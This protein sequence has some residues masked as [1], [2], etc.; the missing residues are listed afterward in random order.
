MNVLD[1]KTFTWSKPHSVPPRYNHSATLVDRKL[2]IYAGKDESGKTVSDLFVVDLDSLKVL[3]QMGLSGE[4]AL[5]KSQHF[6]E[7]IGNQQMMVFG[8]HGE[9]EYGMWLLDLGTLHWKTLPRDRCF[10]DGVWNY[11]TACN[12]DELSGG[13]IN[14]QWEATIKGKDTSI[15]LDGRQKL[16]LFLGN[17]D[18]ERPQPYDHFKDM[19]LVNPEIMFLWQ[20]PEAKL[21]DDFLSL[22]QEGQDWADY[23]IVSSTEE[24]SEPVKC[25]RAVL[26]SRWQHFRHLSRSGMR[27][28]SKAQLRLPESRLVIETFV[29]FLYTDQL[30]DLIDAFV[31]TSLLVMGNLYLLP[32][33]SKLCCRKL[34]TGDFLTVETCAS[35]FQAAV[36]A[37]EEGL[38]ALILE[39]M[40]RH[41]GAILR[42]RSLMNMS[43]QAWEEFLD[44]VPEDGV[45]VSPSKMTNTAA[46]KL[47]S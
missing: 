12:A 7:Y 36:E 41:H 19:L 30:P 29:F 5:L 24:G 32:R 6:T 22:L 4:V 2:Y 44:H 18:H 17:V 43:E 8:K 39:F 16:L 35:I 38:K 46:T 47:S 26:W 28:I 23:E 10:T 45:L 34:A 21:Q 11:F 9:N 33:L 3:P 42:C 31:L 15:N 1:L 40:F 20:V 37:R 25:H 13:G 14:N 27:E